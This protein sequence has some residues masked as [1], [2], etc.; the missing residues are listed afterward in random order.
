MERLL[1]EYPAESYVATATFALA[2]ELH[3]KAPAA[4]TN[5]KL[6]D[7]SITRV[8]LIDTAIHMYDHMLSTW[9]RDPASDQASFALA[10]ALLDLDQYKSAIQRCGQFAERYPESKLLDSF[11][12]V[13][14]Y[15]Q[16]ALGEHTR[17]LEMCKQVSEAKRKDPGTGI[18]LEAA[19]KWQA[20]YIMGQIYHSLGKPAAAIG[21][22]KRVKDRFADA[23]EAIDFFTRKDIRLPEVTTVKPGKATK[24]ELKYRNVSDANI[25]VYRIDLMKFSLMQRNLDR[26]T[27]I[28]LAGI[29]PYHELNQKLGDGLDYGD[30]KKELTLPLTDEGAY[31]VVCRAENLHTSGLVLV[32]P[33]QLEIQEDAAAGRVRVTVKDSIKDTYTRDVHVKVI[34]SNNK[35]FTDG[36]TD[37]RGIFVADAIVGT[38]T[39]IA[40]AGDNR[41]AFYRGKTRLGNVPAAQ[42]NRAKPQP[43]PKPSGSGKSILLKNIEGSNEGIL[44]EQRGNYRSLLD[45]RARGVKAK[46]AF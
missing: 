29:R 13:I 32:T 14:G 36:E 4:K 22:Y 6:R 25:K 2:G 15:S 5:Q 31:L 21:E 42:S 28:N 41:Y 12:Y 34:G 1:H 20:I 35:K 8:D 37:L 40:K 30:Q 23:A 18:E 16:F 24:I 10:N 44:M 33:L 19:N 11:W 39:V 46:K 38:S 45:N 9:P 27:A 3:T 17:A 26:I 7:A 43:P